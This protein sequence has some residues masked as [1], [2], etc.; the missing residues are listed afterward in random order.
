MF[1][2][3]NSPGINKAQNVK[4]GNGSATVLQQGR[5]NSGKQKGLTAID[6]QPLIVSYQADYLPLV[7]A[8][9]AALPAADF[10]V[11]SKYSFT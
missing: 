1:N 3:L 5:G 2:L 4:I 7:P 6:G 11:D 9:L 8:D 10:W